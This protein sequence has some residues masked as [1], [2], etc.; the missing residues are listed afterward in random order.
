[1]GKQYMYKTGFI[2]VVQNREE[3][4]WYVEYRPQ[5]G[6][7]HRLVSKLL[8][9]CAVR[10]TC[11]ENLDAW[12]EEKKLI[13]RPD[14]QCDMKEIPPS[15]MIEGEKYQ[16]KRRDH[17]SKRYSSA[18]Y[19][20]MSGKCHLFYVDC[21]LMHSFSPAALCHYEIRTLTDPVV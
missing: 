9:K 14:E 3:Y 10:R 5:N 15:A 6:R 17:P 12:A 21:R 18:E 13:A 11:Q 16:L 20:G 1:M 2:K 4:E 8:P 19:R 7:A